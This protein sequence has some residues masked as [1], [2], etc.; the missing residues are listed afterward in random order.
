M[1]AAAPPATDPG[2]TTTDN[3]NSVI[4]TI[5]PT[6]VAATITAVTATVPTV[7]A[8]TYAELATAVAFSHTQLTR[9]PDPTPRPT[10]AAAQSRAPVIAQ[11]WKPD[12]RAGAGA[13][14]PT[15]RHGDAG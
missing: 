6:A 3:S 13:G 14:G 5:A 4:T 7:S 15:R 11:A 8:L 12:P 2:T 10:L 1:S 9:A